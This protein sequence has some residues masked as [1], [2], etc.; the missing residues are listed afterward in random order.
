M[1]SEIDSSDMGSWHW[2]EYILSLGGC[3]LSSLCVL[4]NCC[5]CSRGF[6]PW[7]QCLPQL[8]N[9]HAC[10]GSCG[11]RLTC[12]CGGS[13]LRWLMY[14]WWLHLVEI[15]SCSFRFSW[16]H[17]GFGLASDWTIL[18]GWGW[19]QLVGIIHYDDVRHY[20]NLGLLFIGIFNLLVCN[21]EFDLSCC[22]FCVIMV[23]FVVTSS[24][25]NS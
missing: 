4:Q 19:S 15:K 18:F 13:I 2:S 17:V 23:W 21:S 25:P 8:N 9:M 1:L 12:F 10:P 24:S 5:C 22:C 3:L 11:F 7:V 6:G 20:S 14:S 16:L